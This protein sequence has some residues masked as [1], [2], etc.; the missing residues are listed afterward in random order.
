MLK[1]NLMENIT[2]TSVTNND[3]LIKKSSAVIKENAEPVM[4]TGSA[5]FVNLMHV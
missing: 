5:F 2:Y 1:D 4:C 3:R